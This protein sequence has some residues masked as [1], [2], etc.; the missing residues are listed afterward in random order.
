MCVMM[1]LLFC[2]LLF[3]LQSLTLSSHFNI[4]S[5]SHDSR[6]WSHDTRSRSHDTRSR[7]QGTFITQSTKTRSRDSGAT[8]HDHSRH[9]RPGSSYHYTREG[10]YSTTAATQDTLSSPFLGSVGTTHRSSPPSSK[11]NPSSL[12]GAP[13]NFREPKPHPQAHLLTPRSSSDFPVINGVQVKPTGGTRVTRKV[14]RG[15]GGGEER[16]PLTTKEEGTIPLS[17]CKY[18]FIIGYYL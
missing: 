6:K 16:R 7:S 1:C 5:S 18:S 13:V 17:N 3:L 10:G 8:S 11:H 4:G 15:G 9:L 14:A 2:Y 12:F